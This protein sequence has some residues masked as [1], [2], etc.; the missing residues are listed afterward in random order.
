MFCF[1]D[2]KASEILAP[3]PGIEL[4]PPV[5]GGKVLTTELSGKSHL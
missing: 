2:H 3:Q 1:F 4:V 5:L